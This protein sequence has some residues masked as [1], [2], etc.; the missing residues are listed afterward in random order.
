MSCAGWGIEMWGELVYGAV[1]LFGLVFLA[2]A[3]I[4]DV[5]E[6]GRHD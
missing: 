6:A 1:V 3:V 2:L 4:A 5:R